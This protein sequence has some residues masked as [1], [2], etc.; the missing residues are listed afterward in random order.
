VIYDEIA[1]TDGKW[2]EYNCA[3][4]VTYLAFGVA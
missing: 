2:H 1:Y 3:V 4:I